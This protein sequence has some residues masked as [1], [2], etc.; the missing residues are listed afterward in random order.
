MAD[1]VDPKHE[2]LVEHLFQRTC[3][4]MGLRGFSL[5]PL[6]RRLRG[7]GKFRTLMY[8]Y[9]RI[10]D[11]VIT[12]D[13]YTPKTMKPRKLDAIIRVICHELTHHQ[14]PPRR[15][16]WKGRYVVIDHHPRYWRK[17]KKN[18]EV[19]ARDEILCEYFS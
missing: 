11:T 13:L 7:K 2:A 15:C 17:Y 14:E 16:F 1:I 12:V 5:K 4:V 8:G 3:V 19:L 18:M 10:G 9:T 6:R